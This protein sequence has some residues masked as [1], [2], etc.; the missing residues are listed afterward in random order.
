M[1]FSLGVCVWY[2]FTI[3]IQYLDKIKNYKDNWRIIIIFK[4]VCLFFKYIGIHFR[5]IVKI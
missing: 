2:N 1:H 4:N 5:V 3:G